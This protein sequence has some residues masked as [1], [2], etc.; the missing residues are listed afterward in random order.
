MSSSGNKDLPQQP[1]QPNEPV[2]DNNKHT[3]QTIEHTTIYAPNARGLWRCPQ[4]P[5][6]NILVDAPP[7][8]SKLKYII[9]YMRQH[10]IGA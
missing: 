4:D 7:D 6:G 1:L 10:D 3:K 8:L 9:D 5:D 2:C